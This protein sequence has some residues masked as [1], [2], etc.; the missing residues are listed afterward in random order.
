VPFAS[1]EEAL[2]ALADPE[3]PR[4]LAAFAWLSRHPETAELILE[5]FRATLVEMGVRPTGADPATGE[6]VFSLE[7]VARALGLS[8]AE[9]DQAATEAGRPPGPGDPAF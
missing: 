7:D 2:N 5:T 3:S 4:W 9:L 6:A 1:L 8:E